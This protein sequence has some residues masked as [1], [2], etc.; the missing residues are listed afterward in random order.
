MNIFPVYESS[1]LF[2]IQLFRTISTSMM[3][4]MDYYKNSSKKQYKTNMKFR[5][6]IQL[7]SIL[8]STCIYC[9]HNGLQNGLFPDM[10]YTGTIKYHIF[11]TICCRLI[12]IAP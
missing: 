8:G 2:R 11:L 3:A 7:Y 10:C 1:I 6:V 4:F 12:T 9:L 5:L